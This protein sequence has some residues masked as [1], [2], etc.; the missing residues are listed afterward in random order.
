[1]GG[2]ADG[3]FQEHLRQPVT[4]GCA[5]C[6]RLRVDLAFGLPYIGAAE[7]QVGRNTDAYGFHI[8]GQF[9]GL[10]QYGADMLGVSKTT[11]KYEKN[12]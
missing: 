4:L 8:V 11:K 12:K 9:A 1:M 3:T 5:K 2:I 10:L 6:C 7:Q